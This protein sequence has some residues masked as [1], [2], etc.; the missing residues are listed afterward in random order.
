MQVI[1][2]NAHPQ[3]REKTLYIYKSKMKNNS[4]HTNYVIGIDGGSTSTKAVI[5]NEASKILSTENGLPINF[6]IIGEELAAKRVIQLLKKS[7]SKRKINSYTIK[8]LVIGSTG[9]GR[10]SDQK[11]FYKA[12]ILQAKKEKIKIENLQV[13]S[14][15]IIALEGAFGN[16]AGIIIIAGTG[17]IVFGRDVN[18]KFHRVGGWGR[19]IGDEGCGYF[20]GRL[21]INLISRSFDG[22]NSSTLLKN[23]AAKKF[24]FTSQT[25]I[26]NKIYK[27]HF[28]LSKLAP[29]VIQASEKGDLES[30]KIIQLSINE[31][32][33]M[34]ETLVKMGDFSNFI[35]SRNKKPIPIACFGGLVEASNYFK[36]K[37]NRA[38]INSKFKFKIIKG[39]LSPSIGALQIAL[40]KINKI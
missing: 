32:L 39:P 13:I 2:I 29:I 16:S 26:I 6:Q 4:L 33:L 15:A 25:K 7:F 36:N 12:I 5:S 38:L 24:G 20:I 22:R 11:R 19:I 28:E 18:G 35:S 40:K 34:V 14:D 3:V 17:S 8:S 23:L 9:A 27:N 31:L 1:K 30:K 21:A 10:T 37:L